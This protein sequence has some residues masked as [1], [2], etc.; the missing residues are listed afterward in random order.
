MGD[1]KRLGRIGIKALVYF[2]LVFDACAVN[3]VGGGKYLAAW[4]GLQC[5]CGVF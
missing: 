1:A 5:R 3:R 2:E 4:S